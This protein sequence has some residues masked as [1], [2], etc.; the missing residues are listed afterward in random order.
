MISFWHSQGIRGSAARTV[1]V[2]RRGHEVEAG[3]AVA[4]LDERRV[5]ERDLVLGHRGAWEQR[6]LVLS[7]VALEVQHPFKG[8]SNIEVELEVAR[9][10]IRL[11]ERTEVTK[12]KRDSRFKC[13]VRSPGL[14]SLPPSPTRRVAE[15]VWTTEST[16]R[17]RQHGTQE[18]AKGYRLWRGQVRSLTIS[19]ASPDYP[20]C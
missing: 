18:P 8:C 6:V 17:R 9:A 1:N 4:L 20:R 10:G 5:L 2:G 7:L 12:P 15:I 19:L 13:R 3:R 14:R 16:L 11:F